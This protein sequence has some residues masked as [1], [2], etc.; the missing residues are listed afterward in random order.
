MIDGCVMMK[1]LFDFS[2]AA[3]GL[4]VLS[5][6]L[7]GVAVLVK[8]T[9]PGPVFFQQE[10]IGRGFRP[11]MIYKFRS[12]VPDAPR[13]GAEITAGDD[14][15]ITWA[16]RILRKTK[17]DETPQLLN[18][19]KGDMSFVGPRP[20]ARKYVEMFRDDYEEILQVRPGVTD[21]ASIE[22]RN[23]STIL[24]T[25]DDPEKEY[26]ERILP[27]KIRVSK[28]QIR[29]ASFWFDLAIIARTAIVLFPNRASAGGAE[30]HAEDPGDKA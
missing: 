29:R 25:A 14:P 13:L 16:G 2:M 24:G 9:S 23:E 5:P 20:E 27:D 12:M 8:L 6:L 26:I 22:Y 10:R 17:I 21:L 3:V 7:I 28:E 11:F 30:N 15:R 1:R 4:V 19:L 18:V